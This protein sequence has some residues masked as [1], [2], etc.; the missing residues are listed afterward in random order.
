MSVRQIRA[1]PLLAGLVLAACARRQPTAPSP[2][3]F[4]I[5]GHVRLS[6]TVVDTAAVALGSRVLAHVDGVP[7]ELL[8]GS[9]VVAH[10]TTIGGTYRFPGLR[11]GDYVA[12]CRV[13]PGVG[14]ETN[15]MVI[16]V[17]DVETADTLRLESRG[18]LFPVPNP[19]VDTTQ[20]FFGV[21]ESAF[22][23]IDILDLAGRPVKN[24]LALDLAP[25]YQA[26][27]WFGRD[28]TGHPM[29]DSLYWISYVAG[30]DIRAHLLFKQPAPAAVRPARSS[31]RPQAPRPR[32]RAV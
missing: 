8:H 31:A 19:F 20:I 30:P 18:D 2:R 3:L 16:A 24:L 4:A 17:S 15:P 29:T 13:G 11:P 12:R 23:R 21:P 28:Q 32:P 14:D 22:V 27:F 5:T 7:I 1:A 6:G 9:D 10:T 26:V 25:R